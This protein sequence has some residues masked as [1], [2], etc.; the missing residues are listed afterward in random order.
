MRILITGGFGFLGGKLGQYLHR[1]GNEIILGSRDE[2]QSPK[3]LPDSQTVQT[4]WS[5]PLSLEE[6]CLNA[7]IIIHTAGINDRDSTADP[8]LAFAFNGGATAAIV[9]AASTKKIKFFIYL[10]T[11]HVYANPLVGVITEDLPTTN[12]H[13][14]A[15]SHK[16]GEDALLYAIKNGEIKGCVIRLSNSFGAPTDLTVNCWQILVN[17]LCKQA[18]LTKK[19]V[20]RTSGEQK[21]DFIPVTEFCRAIEYLVNYNKTDIPH[22]INVGSGISKTVFEMAQLISQRFKMKFGFEPLLE[23]PEPSALELHQDLQYKSLMP[24][25]MNFSFDQNIEEEI[26]QLLLFCHDAFCLKS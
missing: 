15:T 6:I 12:L 14:Y 18:V 5:N 9:K 17:D 26:D 3:W 1:S 19:M 21:R 25:V 23:R 13:P 22:I 24:M 4:I 7:D 11:A 10:S 20:L 16:A 2:K 8:E